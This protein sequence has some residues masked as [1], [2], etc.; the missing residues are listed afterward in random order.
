MKIKILLLVI[1]TKNKP[2]ADWAQRWLRK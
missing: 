1:R 2:G